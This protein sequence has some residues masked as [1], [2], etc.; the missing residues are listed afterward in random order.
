MYRQKSNSDTD[1]IR[2][3]TDIFIHPKYDPDTLNYDIAL[4]KVDKDFP[5]DSFT[6]RICLPDVMGKGAKS[7]PGKLSFKTNISNF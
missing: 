1:T 2:S 4:A 6:A 5:K 7:L 3:L